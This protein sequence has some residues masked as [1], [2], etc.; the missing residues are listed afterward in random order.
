MKLLRHLGPR[1]PCPR[2]LL[3]EHSWPRVF[4]VM[5]FV[6]EKFVTGEIDATGSSWLK[7]FSIEAFLAKGSRIAQEARGQGACNGGSCG[8]GICGQSAC[9]RGIRDQGSHGPGAYGLMFTIEEITGAI[10]ENARVGRISGGFPRWTKW[11]WRTFDQLSTNRKEMEV[12][13]SRG[14]LP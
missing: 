6:S 9:G 8:Q 5:A 1:F 7:L 14:L 13:T 4:V 2:R 3:P 10:G 11:R 12:K